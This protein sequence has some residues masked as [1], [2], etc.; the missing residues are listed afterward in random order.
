MS[1]RLALSSNS[2][3]VN[4]VVML[5]VIFSPI[6]ADTVR[7]FFWYSDVMFLIVGVLGVG[8]STWLL[9]TR[10]EQFRLGPT[11]AISLLLLGLWAVAT[12]LLT[13]QNV[14][15]FAVWILAT[16]LPFLFLIVSA[17]FWS[18]DPD[19][20]KWL[21]YSCT[22]WVVIMAVVGFLEVWLGINHPINHL[23]QEV[24]IGSTEI[25]HG[26]GDYTVA[27]GSGDSSY[28]GVE[29]IF[30]PTSIFLSNG[31]FGQAL[32]VLVLFRWI[33]LYRESRKVSL[34]VLASV[35]FDILALLISGQRAALV[36]LSVFGALAIAVGVAKGNRRSINILTGVVVLACLGLAA[37]IV[38][39]PSLGGLVT[40]RY[41]SG[42][43]DVSERIMD[44]LI[45]PS[46]TIVGLYGVVGAGPGFFSIG[47]S[48]FGGTM[49]WQVL[50]TNGNAEGVWM[51]VIAELGVLG[52]L[53]YAGYHAGLVYQASRRLRTGPKQTH[54]ASLFAVAWLIGV[55]LW[56]ITH[57]TFANAFGMSLGFGFCGGAFCRFQVSVAGLTKY[58]IGRTRSSQRT[59][60]PSL[61][62]QLPVR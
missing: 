61:L 56:G 16:Y 8:T 15:I 9:C 10:R 42:F 24:D 13:H 39:N 59:F 4:R 58:R 23:P 49:M 43:T 37:L 52:L 48:K 2:P 30:R 32:F 7:R 41:V 40:D 3:L 38:I 26:I 62:P 22:V 20:G 12:F 46:A 29:G 54:T 50:A 57:D 53:M 51:R 36:L 45:V 33:Y 18:S 6:W 11:P 28:S 60:R 19:A 21:Y 47:S 5:T 35:V 34:S 17:H 27:N 14:K 55:A 44:N 31:K 25:R 1:P